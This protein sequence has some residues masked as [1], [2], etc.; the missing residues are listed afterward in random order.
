MFTKG[1]MGNTEYA[2]AFHALVLPILSAFNPDL[3]IVS[4]GF[5]AVCGDPIGDCNVTPIMYYHMT[6]SLLQ[7]IE[8]VPIVVALE[9]G[10]NL[11]VLPLCMESV[12][13]ALLDEKWV[14]DT[15]SKTKNGADNNPKTNN[16]K[17]C[18]DISKQL[19][20]IKLTNNSMLENGRHEMINYLPKSYDEE[21]INPITK[22]AIQSINKSIRAIRSCWKDISLKEIKITKK[23]I[24]RNIRASSIKDHLPDIDVDELASD[25][26]KVN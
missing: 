10:Y 13:L 11:D 15:Q 20:S 6:R 17:D 4:C 1:G 5:D 16:A 25:L 8:H 19:E 23:K 22:N 21:N 18:D 24:N 26:K 9:G 14:E 12:A 3:I 7:T 2:I